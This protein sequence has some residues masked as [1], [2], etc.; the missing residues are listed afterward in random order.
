MKYLYSSTVATLVTSSTIYTIVDSAKQNAQKWLIEVKEKADQNGVRLKIEFIVDPAL[1]VGAIVDYA[2]HQN[3]DLIIIGSIGLSDLKLLLGSTVSGVV[4][5]AH[6]PVL[7][8][9]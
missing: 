9:K 2:E 7:V 5:Y 1:V 4:T 6:R 3:I 8:V